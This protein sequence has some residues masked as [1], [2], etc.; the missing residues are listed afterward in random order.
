MDEGHESAPEMDKTEMSK[1]PGANEG[2]KAIG[3]S[4]DEDRPAIRGF[5]Q[6][7]MESCES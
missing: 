3:T 5:S 2:A 4:K 6:M 7:A 1:T